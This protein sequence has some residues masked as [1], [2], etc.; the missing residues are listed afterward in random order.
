[1]RKAAVL[2]DKTPKN[3]NDGYDE[4]GFAI[5]PKLVYRFSKFLDLYAVADKY[6]DDDGLIPFEFMDWPGQ[7]L[8]EE[9]DQQM[10]AQKVLD[11]NKEL[12]AV[13]ECMQVLEFEGRSD[14]FVDYLCN[15]D[16]GLDITALGMIGR[17]PLVEHSM[18][19]GGCSE[20]KLGVKS[21]T[22][23]E[24]GELIETV[25]P[26]NKLY[27]L[28][29]NLPKNRNDKEIKCAFWPVPPGKMY[30]AS[31]NMSLLSGYV[32][33]LVVGEDILRKLV[34]PNNLSLDGEAYVPRF[35]SQVIQ[36]T[37]VFSKDI[38]T[39]LD[40]AFSSDRLILGM[41]CGVILV[42]NI[43]QEEL[44]FDVAYMSNL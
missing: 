30:L 5:P 6:K 11:V 35:D 13:K 20:D 36:C 26:H 23:D 37:E 40:F 15:A 14:K 42:K 25:E 43:N 29:C 10:G 9:L 17:E 24:K 34:Q 1:V 4:V 31:G 27:N 12:G 41:K 3:L 38:R 32:Q 28:R 2:T 16:E 8:E 44:M 39:V 21:F 19:G 18:E 33:P 22:E 7:K